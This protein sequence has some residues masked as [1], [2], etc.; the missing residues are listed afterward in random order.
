MKKYALVALLSVVALAGCNNNENKC[1]K[2]RAA[3]GCPLSEENI[4]RKPSKSWSFSKE[5]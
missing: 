4:I 2:D 3:K 5:S 1:L